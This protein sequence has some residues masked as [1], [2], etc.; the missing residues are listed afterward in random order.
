MEQLPKNL[1]SLQNGSFP[2]LEWALFYFIASHEL[3][4]RLQQVE[5]NTVLTV[6]EFELLGARKYPCSKPFLN[7]DCSAAILS[8]VNLRGALALLLYQRSKRR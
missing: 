2:Q 7:D 3:L 6:K 4:Y 8:A 5:G 1:V